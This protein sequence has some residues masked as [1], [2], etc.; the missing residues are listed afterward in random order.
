MQRLAVALVAGV[1]FFAGCSSGGGNKASS[2]EAKEAI[3]SAG[4][5]YCKLARNLEGLDD[6]LGFGDSEGPLTDEQIQDL[7][8]VI[9]A[10]LENA[11]DEIKDDAALLASSLDALIEYLEIVGGDF[12]ADPS[13]L[14]E[15]DQKRIEE[16][17][18]QF[19]DPKFQKASDNVDTYNEEECGITPDE[20]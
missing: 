4:G 1:V 16:L 2:K 14:S 13:T 18:Q 3:A 17:S 15:E 12:L 6:E 20:E 10:F 8:A 7:K 5:D 19:E 11:P 9:A